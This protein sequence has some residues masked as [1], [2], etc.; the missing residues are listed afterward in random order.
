MKTTLIFLTV[1]AWLFTAIAPASADRLADFVGYFELGQNPANPDW[2]NPAYALDDASIYGVSL[3]N[4]TD[5][6][7]PIPSWLTGGYNVNQGIDPG[8]LVVGFNDP[9]INQGQGVMDLLI[10]GNP[11]TDG[12][13]DQP[14]WYEPG[15]IEV[16]RETTAPT[17]SVDGWA[18][19]TFYLIKP[20]NYDW[21]K[22]MVDQ[23]QLNNHDPRL[24]PLPID[25]AWA[26]DDTSGQGSAD[27][28]RDDHWKLTAQ[29]N[30]LYGYADVHLDGDRVDL[31]DAIDM[32]GN[33]VALA[34]I[35]YVRIRTV[36]DSEADQFGSFSTEVMYVQ[37]LGEVPEPTGLVLLGLAGCLIRRRRN[38]RP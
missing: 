15:Y 12:D 38:L 35:S 5:N 7:N 28:Y 9:V 31:S 2:L 3:G 14:G 10:M 17:A 21:M 37:A 22:D 23:G 11:L 24:G 8:G 6:T 1:S 19:E 27:S 4:W 20:G 30:D 29:T 25:Y 33:P 16:A 13:T 18:D 36:S 32:D 34:D 26:G